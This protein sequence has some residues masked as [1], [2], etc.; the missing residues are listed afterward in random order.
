MADNN[1]NDDLD[2]VF[3][4]ADL[5]V[6]AAADADAK[7]AVAH[8]AVMAAADKII[9][10]AQ[11]SLTRL[12]EYLK[13]GEASPI[14]AV[15]WPTGAPIPPGPLPI[16]QQTAEPV[17][18]VAQLELPFDGFP[19]VVVE[20]APVAPAPVVE[21]PVAPVPVVEAVVEAAPVD[22]PVE[23]A[24]VD[25]SPVVDVIPVEPVGG[26]AA[27]QEPAFPA[28]GAAEPVA[29]EPAVIADS[30]A[31][32]PTVTELI[33]AVDAAPVVADGDAIPEGGIINNG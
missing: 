28:D 18:P 4:E 14:I 13:P 22:P 23:A 2:E 33:A 29:A 26:E 30:Q 32:E 7:Q 24:P 19:T 27:P 17:N 6:A 31:V 15:L 8:S 11:R 16:D 5:A 1:L 3:R 21:A 10:T 9:N 25:T 20:E 12:Y